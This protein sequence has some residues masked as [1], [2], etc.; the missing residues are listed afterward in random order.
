MTLLLALLIGV[1]AGLRSM[2]APAAVT[3][4]AHLG[5]LGIGG[6]WMAFLAQPWANFS[7]VAAACLELVAD[8]RPWIPSRTTLLPFAARIGSGA[9]SGAAVGSAGGVWPAGLVVG[10][11]GA[12]IGAVG[13]HAVRARLAK[14]LGRDLPAALIEDAIAVAVALVVVL[15][16]WPAGGS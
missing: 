9:L 4:M 15:A 8:T 7:L 11:V 16:L 12:A 6:T 3:V 13:G 1:V 2:M 10:A 5:G 14:A